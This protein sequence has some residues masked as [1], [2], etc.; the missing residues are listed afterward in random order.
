ME[1]SA[2]R[3]SPATTASRH[4]L[5]CTASAFSELG[6]DAEFRSIECRMSIAVNVTERYDDAIEVT[7]SRRRSRSA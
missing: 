2:L 4:S 7:F 3:A 1:F 5:C 6:I